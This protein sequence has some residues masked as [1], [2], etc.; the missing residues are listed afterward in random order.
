MQARREC[1]ISDCE[2]NDDESEWSLNTYE[3][4]SSENDEYS[5]DEYK[6]HYFDPTKITTS[7]PLLPFNNQVGGH[8]PFFR[9][10][11]RAICKPVT[12]REQV[13]YE[14][15]DG[16]HHELL[17]FT[18]QYMGV[19]NV[20]YR[21]LDNALDPPVPEVL[22]EKNK[23]L[24][25]DWQACA[26]K[27]HQRQQQ[28]QQ[29]QCYIGRRHSCS[30]EAHELLRAS[31]NNR[32]R[33]TRSRKF[34]E[35]VLKEVFSP[36]AL[37]ERLMLAEDWKR[38]NRLMSHEEKLKPLKSSPAIPTTA[39]AADSTFTSWNTNESKIAQSYSDHHLNKE[40]SWKD[41]NPISHGG[42]S[43]PVMM[44]GLSFCNLEKLNVFSSSD[45]IRRNSGDRGDGF[46]DDDSMTLTGS[47]DHMTLEPRRP[48][49]II[50][51]SSS[52]DICTKNSQSLNDH[53]STNHDEGA[54]FTM[55]DIDIGKNSRREK[56]SKKKI[57]LL[58]VDSICLSS[59]SRQSKNNNNNNNNN[60]KTLDT[61]NNN[62]NNN[63]PN[64]NHHH[65]SP[66]PPDNPWSLQIYNRDLQKMRNRKQSTSSDEV[67][68]QNN[69]Q[70]YILIEDLTDGVRYPCVL[71]LK[72]GTRQ[73][74]VY[75][76]REKMKSQTIKCE[77]STSKVLGVRVCGMQVYKKNSSEFIFQ[78]K[79]YGRTL[80]PVTFRDTLEAYLDNGQGCQIQHIPV[81]VR[82][83]RRLARI[84][85][86]MDDYRLY[87]SSLLMIYD[88]S[89]TTTDTRK[90][91]DVR[92][93]DFANCVTAE[94]VQFRQDEFTYP[95]RN[96]GP[97]NGYLL[98]L[99]T[100]VLCF[101]WIYRKHGGLS[102]DLYV[103]SDNVFDDIYEPANDEVLSS[104]LL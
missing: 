14:N 98:G 48:S 58:Q 61:N 75:A 12:A 5:S 22:F 7:L 53:D 103:Q 37:R 79:Y 10:S 101:E 41:E 30:P 1:H 15:I 17:P 96:K 31:S 69:V 59:S 44:S 36:E 19:L 43:A 4:S 20:T 64:N 78:D 104:I 86:K 18:C 38:K 57:P 27:K 54:I 67:S 56:I 90:K 62:N 60:N 77:K 21:S 94:D 83:L 24:L 6:D 51:P 34:Q 32:F 72:M 74:G 97:D 11:K 91:I 13:F 85:K 23:H 70:K 68:Q 2:D 65:N 39:T 47:I 102:E 84:I 71:D 26:F 81:I 42:S 66:R 8:A 50:S 28:Q 55:D 49:M 100:L 45:F 95:P 88:G 3:S 82:K 76:T 93:I 16:Q 92:I 29:Q 9:F 52:P 33:A 46:G 80:T 25:R 89:P 35:Q 40:K 73:Y 63:N 87:A 99:K